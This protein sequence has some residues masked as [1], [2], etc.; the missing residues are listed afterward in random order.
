MALY[1]PAALLAITFLYT[2][3]LS[4][5]AGVECFHPN[6]QGWT[7]RLFMN[8]YCWESLTG[9]NSP[10]DREITVRNATDSDL[11]IWTD[12]SSTENLNYHRAFPFAILTCIFVGLLP[13]IFWSV[14]DLDRKI[15]I[16]A[17]YLEMGI[18]ESLQLTL[19]QMV[20]AAWTEFVR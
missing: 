8:N 15:K 9:Y 17:D 5:D 20:E 1:A 3:E 7:E 14:I 2:A 10:M 19:R 6:G 16:E 11:Q 18:E 12:S 13:T 4:K